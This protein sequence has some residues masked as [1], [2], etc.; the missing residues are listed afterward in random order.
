M[1]DVY[2]QRAGLPKK[3]ITLFDLSFHQLNCELT[4]PHDNA[5]R[6]TS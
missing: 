6:I 3:N 4:K 2:T 5:T 1:K